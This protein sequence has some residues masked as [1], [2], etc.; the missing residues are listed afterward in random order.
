M[1]HIPKKAEI[2]L[3]KR[4]IISRP[5][6]IVWL[7]GSQHTTPKLCL[8]LHWKKEKESQIA[9]QCFCTLGFRRLWHLAAHIA[10]LFIW[11]LE[12]KGHYQRTK[13]KRTKYDFLSWWDLPVSTYG[14]NY[15]RSITVLSP[16]YKTSVFSCSARKPTKANHNDVKKIKQELWNLTLSVFFCCL[17]YLC[18]LC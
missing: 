15:V 9:S 12:K 8:M 2:S 5:R 3:T 11:F 14:M 10:E 13:K 6:K 4:K 16:T 7:W 18:L 17:L 1:A